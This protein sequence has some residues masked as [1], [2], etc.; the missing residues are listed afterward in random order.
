[1]ITARIAGLILVLVGCALLLG[2]GY[3]MGMH[4]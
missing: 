1:M 3:S 2:L 4:P